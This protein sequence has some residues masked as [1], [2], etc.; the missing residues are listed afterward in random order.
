MTDFKEGFSNAKEKAEAKLAGLAEIVTTKG[1]TKWLI[2]VALVLLV[3]VVGMVLWPAHATGGHH[4]GVE[5]VIPKPAV[6]VPPAVP[7]NAAPAA[8]P[9]ATPAAAASQPSAPAQQPSGPVGKW[10]DPVGPFVFAG[11]GIYFGAFIRSHWIFCAQREEE[12]HRD[13]KAA[14]CYNAERDGLPESK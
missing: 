12:W 14:R 11:V 8:A 10:G 5:M 4:Y 9:A 1:W 3:L 2:V 13:N 6:P 7:P